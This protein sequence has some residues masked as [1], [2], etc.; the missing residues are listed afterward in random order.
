[1]AEDVENGFFSS[2]SGHVCCFEIVVGGAVV[3]LVEVLGKP[4]C[5][6]HFWY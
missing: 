3:V 6:I 2:R 4:E 1:M 5:L